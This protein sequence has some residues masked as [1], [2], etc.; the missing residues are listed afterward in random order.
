MPN[1]RDEIGHGLTGTG[2]CLDGE[3]LARFEGLGDGLGHLDLT[4]AGAAADPVDGGVLMRAGHTEAAVDLATLAGFAP[5]G[6]IV[7]IVGDH[8]E[9]LRLHEL[10]PWAEKHGLKVSTIE[11]L[12]EYRLAQSQQS[13]A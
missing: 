2:A 5:M 4:W 12:R 11:R 6:V 3:V 8:G 7:E 9:M 13:V 1:G 10:L